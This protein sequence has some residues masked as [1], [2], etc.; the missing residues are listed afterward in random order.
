MFLSIRLGD[1]PLLRDGMSACRRS[2]VTERR[3]R[4]AWSSGGR[5]NRTVRGLL[6]AAPRLTLWD[7]SDSST[8]DFAKAFYGRLQ[9]G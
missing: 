9:G 6:Y 2:A 1:G 8:A 4:Q 7:V 5:A 3:H